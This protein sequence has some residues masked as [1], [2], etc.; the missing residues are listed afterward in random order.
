MRRKGILQGSHNPSEEQAKQEFSMMQPASSS[1]LL[2]CV[3]SQSR[4]YVIGHLA[5]GNI[6]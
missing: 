6:I 3:M 2:Q 5:L 4:Q 1:D